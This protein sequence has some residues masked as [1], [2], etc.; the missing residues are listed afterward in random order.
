MTNSIS[1]GLKFT[2]FQDK[3]SRGLSLALRI[4]SR[5]ISL[6]ILEN[7]L[8]KTEAGRLSVLA[9]NLEEAIEVKIAG[10]VVS[11]GKITIPAGIFS[12]IVS[13]LPEEK[14]TLEAKDK[15]LEIT[16]L[17]YKAELKIQG[18]EDF[19]VF[20]E[21]KPE[22]IFELNSKEIKKGLEQ[23]LNIV[24][25]SG[26]RP[27]ISGV[28]WR[29]LD[30]E[31]KLVAT[32]SFRLGEKTIQLK[33]KAAEKDLDSNF[34][35]ILPLRAAVELNRLLEAAGETFKLSFDKNQALFDLDGI[36]LNTRLLEGNYP[37]YEQ[38]VPE[39][40]ETEFSIDKAELFKKVR[41]VSILASDSYAIHLDLDSAKNEIKL[42]A[43]SS[44][45]GRSVVLLKRNVKGNS[46]QASFNWRYLIDGLNNLEDDQVVFRLNGSSRPAMLKSK[47]HSDY[48]Y[49]AMPIK[50]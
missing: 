34:S 10:K 32:D 11:V 24:T 14:I 20:P 26:V 27:E 50:E 48:F 30:K 17:D 38:I 28:F 8:L 12:S 13:N 15:I 41:L 16:S 39:K 5:N 22:V 21:L 33:N 49:L 42:Q 19:P 43:A 23:V 47:S 46:A 9:T 3:L 45:T 2:A 36:K 37:N 7:F 29:F 35:F 31:L 6:P 44:V 4:I 40:F 18:A 1:K 25:V